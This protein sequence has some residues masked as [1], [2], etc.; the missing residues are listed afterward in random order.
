MLQSHR[1]RNINVVYG[2]NQKRLKKDLN[3]L[4][5]NG[6]RVIG[7][8]NKRLTSEQNRLNKRMDECNKE[9]RVNFNRCDLYICVF[10]QLQ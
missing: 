9:N 5:S 1:T 3:V 6:R 2:L 8:M 7:V 10:I 4:I